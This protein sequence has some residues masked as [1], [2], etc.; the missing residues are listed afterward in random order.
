MTEDPALHANM[1]EVRMLSRRV[2]SGAAHIPAR[3]AEIR[4]LREAGYTYREIG[5]AT[6]LGR[7]TLYVIISRTAE[8]KS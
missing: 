6:G 2:R 5:E 8:E 3:D 4:R 1:A 7:A